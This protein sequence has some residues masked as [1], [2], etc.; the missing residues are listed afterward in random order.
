ML[1]RIEKVKLNFFG[2]LRPI[3]LLNSFVQNLCDQARKYVPDYYVFFVGSPRVPGDEDDFDADDFDNDFHVKNHQGD[4]DK[5]HD[6]NQSVI[7][8][9]LLYKS[10]CYGEFDLR[11]NIILYKSEKPECLEPI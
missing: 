1:I 8:F 10:N 3:K 5:K 9:N 4:S 2:F 7:C 11:S 6:D